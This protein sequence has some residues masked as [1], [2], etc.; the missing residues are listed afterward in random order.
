MRIMLVYLIVVVI[1]ES[2]AVFIGLQLDKT[3]PLLALP[4]ALTLFFGGL[5]AGWYIA[6]Y[7]TER[8]LSGAPKR[9]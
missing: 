9:R 8:W 5:A 6:L 3:F 7:I 4:I 1:I 2:I